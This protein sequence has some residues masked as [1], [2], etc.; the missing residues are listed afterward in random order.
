MD[1]APDTT[2]VAPEITHLPDIRY[3][4]ISGVSYLL[5]YRIAMYLPNTNLNVIATTLLSLVLIL[6]FTVT[7]ARS[8]KT[9]RSVALLQIS[10]LT[11]WVLMKVRTFAF[12][13]HLLPG[14][15]GLVMVG[16]AVSVGLIVSSLMKEMKILLPAAVMLA[17]VDLYVVFGGGL[18][19]QAVSGHSPKAQAAMKALT[20]NL[21]TTQ[22]KAGAEPYQLAVGF[23]DFLFIAVFFACF[24]RF[25]I[26]SRKTFVVLVTVLVLYMFAVAFTGTPLPALVPI[27]VV[28][29][30]LNFRH[31]KYDRSEKF[32]LLYAGLIVGV[33]FAYLLHASRRPAPPDKEA[34]P[35][36]N[37]KA[38]PLG[39]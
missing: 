25:G 31:F 26:P 28:V 27:A 4:V 37:E 6:T 13:P 24:R 38:I 19:T 29:I 39:G 16:L 15:D 14:V 30:S 11:L 34:T 8:L 35:I 10:S 9:W 33:L 7:L 18:V 20:V 36:T 22:V 17:M 3:A 2:P 23:A 32:A 12:I 5:L 21:P 1:T